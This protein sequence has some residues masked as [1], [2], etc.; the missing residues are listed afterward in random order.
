VL[1]V[2]QDDTTLKTLKDVLRAELKGQDQT[3]SSALRLLSENKNWSLTVRSLRP[4]SAEEDQT[5]SERLYLLDALWEITAGNAGL[6][7]FLALKSG[8][9]S[10]NTFASKNYVIPLSGEGYNLTEQQR[11]DFQSRLF[12]SVP[13]A[14]LKG[15][16]VSGSIPTGTPNGN[17][18][19]N[20]V[21]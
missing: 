13:T 8:T 12:C 9:D 21:A 11:A 19:G 6:L 15:L 1:I 2:L 4:S 5:R 14:V 3:L 7:S 18:A 10:L 17:P 16:V 20:Q